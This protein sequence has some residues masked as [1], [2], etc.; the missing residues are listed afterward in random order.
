M[1]ARSPKPLAKSRILVADEQPLLR[2]GVVHFINRKDDLVV[3]GEADS[4]ASARTEAARLVPDLLLLDEPVAEG[5]PVG[6][7]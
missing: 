2:A 3:C 1:K 7:G 4:I 5:D 6:F